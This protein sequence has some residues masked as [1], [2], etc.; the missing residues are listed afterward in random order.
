VK[1]TRVVGQW[2]L[3]LCLPVM[4]LTASVSWAVNSPWLYHYGFDK[5]KVGE[6]TGLAQSELDRVAAGLR[7]YFNS[8]DESISLAVVKDGETFEVFNER[9]VA[10]LRDV[11]GLFGLAY[12]LLLGTVV[13]TGIYAVVSLFWWRDRRIYRGLVFGGGLTLLLMLFIGLGVAINFDWLFRQ[14]HLISFANDLWML[15]PATDYLIMLFPRG[16]WFDA[17]IFCAVVTTVGA[18]ILGGMGWWCL[19]KSTT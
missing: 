5:Y 19:K 17:A 8:G 6:T 16:F 12:Y 10:H 14:F 2:L 18:L 13:Y 1:T 4:L 15:D 7:E 3:V 11:K 9:E